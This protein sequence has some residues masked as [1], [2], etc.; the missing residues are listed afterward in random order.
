M[1]VGRLPTLLAALALSLAPLA[2]DQA[3]DDDDATG[4][5]DSSGDDD[6]SSGDDDD[7]SGDDD[8]TADSLRIL[9]AVPAVNAV[10]VPVDGAL[11][12]TF[13]ADVD[14]DTLTADSVLLSTR[15]AGFL[16]V[17][18]AYDADSGC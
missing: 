2:C 12:V 15:Q 11:S 18:L 7:S 1:A 10:D 14:Q 5:D 16:D 17:A 13:T 9:S 3:S 6:D 8:T 4:D